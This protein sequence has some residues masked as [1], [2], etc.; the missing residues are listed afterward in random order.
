MNYFVSDI[1]GAAEEYMRL[2]DK[3]GLKKNDTLYILG[4]IFD[5]NHAD[6]EANLIILRDIMQSDNIQLLLGDHEYAHIMY[7]LS[8]NKGSDA[9]EWENHICSREFQGQ[10]LH[11]L[12]QNYLTPREYDRYMGFLLEQPMTNFITI[13][14]KHFYLCH[15]SPCICM[16]DPGIWQCD[17]V[18]TPLDLHQDYKAAITTDPDMKEFLKKSS[19]LNPEKA[20]IMAGHIPTRYYFEDNETLLKA[21]YPDTEGIKCQKILVTNGKV[22]LNCGCQASTFGMIQNGWVSDLSCLGVDAAGFFVIHLSED[23]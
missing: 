4:D 6:P 21:C 23:T 17:V 10:K 16:N 9:I 15:G 18:S 1:H 13:G 20:I 8:R 19:T 11:K 7:Y 14:D 5:G 12:F 22:L 2:K 3:I